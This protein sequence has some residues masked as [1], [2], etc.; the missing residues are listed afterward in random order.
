[1]GYRLI[2]AFLFAIGTALFVAAA[3]PKKKRAAS[4]PKVELRTGDLVFQSSHSRQAQWIEKATESPYSHVGIIEVKNGAPVVIEAVEPVK[5]TEWK[6]WWQRGRERRVT[7]LRLADLS[8]A[9]AQAVASAA[10]SFL[11]RPY[12]AQFDWDDEKIY[13]ADL[14][15]K[16][17]D[18]GAHVTLGQFQ[19]LG[20]L[21][22]AGMEA[23]LHERFGETL[24][25]ER[26]L[27]TP[28]SVAADPH[29]VRIWSS[30]P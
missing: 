17:F 7:V 8:E 27:V 2:I 12:D 13:C 20:A 29:L 28:A 24:P 23:A 16:A 15:V 14:V 6:T 26:A 25:L 19:R 1:V 21:H 22:L 3:I 9:D 30:F 4:E 5:R 11:G 10:E 18:Q